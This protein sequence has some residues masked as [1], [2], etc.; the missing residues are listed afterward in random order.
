MSEPIDKILYENAKN[1]IKKRVSVWPSAY[2]SGQVVALY[3]KW[4]GKYKGSKQ[5]STNLSRW[6]KEDWRNVCEQST[7]GQY[8]KCGRIKSTQ[9]NYP[10]CRPRNRIS[11][12]TPKTIREIGSNKIKEMCKRKRNS[13]NRS[14]GKQTRIRLVS[15]RTS[16]GGG[17]GGRRLPLGTKFKRGTGRYKYTALI[18]LN[19]G[20][21]KIVHFGHR[22]YQ[23]YHDSVPLSMGGGIWSHKNHNDK[24]RR[25]NYRK[26]HA[27]IKNKSGTFAYNDKL[28]PSWFSYYYLW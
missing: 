4:G 20:K 27:S 10:Y 25:I 11:S 17:G 16:Y 21:T 5:N 14:N 2:A 15:R 19:N 3:K 13:V 26:R 28:S 18:P 9:L 24:I 12:K 8:E 22:D 6:H 1:V 7:N 23:H